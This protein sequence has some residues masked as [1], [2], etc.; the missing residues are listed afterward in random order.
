MT[1]PW[2]SLAVAAALATSAAPVLAQTYQVDPSHTYPSFRAPH[3]GISWWTGK[4][5][6]TTGTV[7]LDRSAGTGTVAIEIDAASVDFGHERMNEHARKS[8]F[9][10]VAQHPTITYRGPI[11]FEGGNP[12]AVDGELTLL[13]KTLPVPLRINS[14]KCIMHPMLKKEV[15][16]ADASGR[17]DRR[18][19]GMT[20]AAR[21]EAAGAAELLIQIEAVRQDD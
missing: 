12:V 20:Y 6:Q 7:S 2:C 21:D 8:D 15:C 11:R 17:F 3:L 5:N 4:F 16:G 1:R 14:F 9:F 19:F 10:D 13:G 18:D